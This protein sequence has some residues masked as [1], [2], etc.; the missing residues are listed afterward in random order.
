MF[1]KS[2]RVSLCHNGGINLPFENQC[3]FASSEKEEV[4][5]FTKGREIMR[6]TMSRS[7]SDGEW[8]MS[9]L[10]DHLGLLSQ[11]RHIQISKSFGNVRQL[12]MS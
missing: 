5:D 8:R 3:S 10:F 1:Q 2:S 9:G 6:F 7:V 11:S 4:W 12:T